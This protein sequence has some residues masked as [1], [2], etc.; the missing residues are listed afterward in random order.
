[1]PSVTYLCFESAGS[2]RATRTCTVEL[3]SAS[4]ACGLG[5]HVTIPQFNPFFFAIPLAF[6]GESARERVAYAS[7]EALSA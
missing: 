7:E 4:L 2:L 3:A 5:P 1:M 6:T